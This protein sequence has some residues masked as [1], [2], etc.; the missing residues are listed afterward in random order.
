M[1]HRALGIGRCESDD[2]WFK[3]ERDRHEHREAF[4]SDA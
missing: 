4:V 2:P 1:R 3:I